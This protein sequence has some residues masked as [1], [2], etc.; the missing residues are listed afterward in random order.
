MTSVV[1]EDMTKSYLKCD[2][3]VGVT[4]KELIHWVFYIH[5]NTMR[6]KGEVIKLG[7]RVV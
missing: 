6:E 4:V 1:K 5:H 2:A 7:R 3:R